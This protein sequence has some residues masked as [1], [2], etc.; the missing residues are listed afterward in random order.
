[1]TMRFRLN[2]ILIRPKAHFSPRMLS[3]LL[4]KICDADIPNK[5]SAP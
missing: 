4:K 1:M 5:H 3:V 2:Y